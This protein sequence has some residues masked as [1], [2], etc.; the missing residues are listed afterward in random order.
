MKSTLRTKFSDIFIAEG[1]LRQVTTED[2][3]GYYPDLSVVI[4]VGGVNYIHNHLFIG[5]ANAL[6]DAEAF[7]EAVSDKGDVF[8]SHWV[9][10]E[11]TEFSYSSGNSEP[12]DSEEEYFLGERNL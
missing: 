9:Q 6:N 5:S 12:Y 10:V 11:D 7:L 8:L 1:N 3:V 4:T 2:G